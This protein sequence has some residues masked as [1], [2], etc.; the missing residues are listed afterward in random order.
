MTQF[1]VPSAPCTPSLEIQISRRRNFIS[2]ARSGDPPLYKRQWSKPSPRRRNAKRQD[3]CLRRPYKY[4]EKKRRERQRRIGNMYPSEWVPKNSKERESFLS[5]QCKEIEENNRVGKTKVL[6]KK[7]R[8]TKGAFY[9]KMDTLKNRNGMDPTKAQILRRDGRNTQKNL[10]K[11]IL[12]THITT[13][14]WSLT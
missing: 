3:G 11:K 1:Q 10:T 5:D 7:I 4:W 8:D 12:M 9:A 14:V 6:L 2:Q 13:M